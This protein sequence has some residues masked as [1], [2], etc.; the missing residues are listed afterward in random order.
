[1]TDFEQWKNEL[2]SPKL[3]NSF[4][5]ESGL[6][7]ISDLAQLLDQSIPQIA[8]TAVRQYFSEADTKLAELPDAYANDEKSLTLV[9]FRFPAETSY[10]IDNEADRLQADRNNLVA[11]LTECYSYSKLTFFSSGI[12]L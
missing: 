5:T 7:G 8:I 6:S 12:G 1:M 10:E 3:Y 11:F 9:T 4:F 2:W